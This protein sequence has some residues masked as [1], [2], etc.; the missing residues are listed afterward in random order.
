MNAAAIALYALVAVAGTLVVAAGFTR[1][2]RDRI[3][4][5]VRVAA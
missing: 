4:Q 5:L 3:N 2:I 1:A